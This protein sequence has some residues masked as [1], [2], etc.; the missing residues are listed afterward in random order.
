[1]LYRNM[2]YEKSHWQHTWGILLKLN[3]LCIVDGHFEV[4]YC[5]S[6]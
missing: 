2:K 1:M 3:Y 5:L 6:C 4:S